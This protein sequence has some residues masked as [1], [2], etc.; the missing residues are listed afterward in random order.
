MT[1]PWLDYICKDPI[2]SKV[3][4]TVMGLEVRPI[5]FLSKIQLVTKFAYDLS[6]FIP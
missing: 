1:S 5:F 3:T 2:S 4:F 6:S